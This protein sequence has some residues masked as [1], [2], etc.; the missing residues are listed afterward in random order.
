[1]TVI[2]ATKVMEHRGKNR[3]W[4]QGQRLTKAGFE[5]DARYRLV[6]KKG[7]LHL[8]SDSH[9][10]YKVSGRR[11]N[12][13]PI[14]DLKSQE[15]AQHFT[16]SE[17]L[18][19]I[20]HKGRIIIRRMMQALKSKTRAARLCRKIIRGEKLDTGC[21]F[22]GGGVMARSIHDGLK[23]AG[24]DSRVA[25]AVEIEGKYMDA[26]LRANRD[27]FDDES[28][29]VNGA[30]Q[31]FTMGTVPKLDIIHCGVPCTGASVAGR[32]KCGTTF[33]ESHSAAGAMFFHTLNWIQNTEAPLV[34]LENVKQYLNTASM[35]VIRS[36]LSSWGYNVHEAV[37]NGNHFGALEG[38]E[39]LV[40][41]AITAELEADTAFKFERLFSLQEKPATVGDI[42][43]P[44]CDDDPRWKEYSYLVEK[45]QRDLAAGKGFRRQLVD[46]SSDRV[47]TITREYNK[48]R[49]TDFFLKHPTDESL[50]RLF[51]PVEHGRLKGLPEGWVQ[52][53]EVS[54]TVAHEVLGQGVVYPK[55]K[56][57]GA[58]LAEWLKE[59]TGVADEVT[60]KALAA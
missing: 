8:I 26:S 41:V 50:T 42:L 18:I 55:F 43:E 13:D 12:R 48:A 60:P 4:L 40:V 10:Q 34:I 33:A 38:R 30:I 47:G 27:I 11:A 52:S 28:L 53:L 23:V 57:L 54:V 36:V 46:A 39:R 20:L 2:I 45:E 49:S 31:D 19:A 44:L 6:M 7:T 17:K 9:G 3:I 5:M 58:G 21:L 56:A 22:H 25:V 1:M 16:T 14:I 15:V 37:L 24:I 35:E 29:L 51:T 32:A 59:V